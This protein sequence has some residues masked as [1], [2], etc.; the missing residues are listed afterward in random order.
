M[1]VKTNNVKSIDEKQL[2]RRIADM[3]MWNREYGADLLEESR[4]A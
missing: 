2:L 3:V 1:F 4:I